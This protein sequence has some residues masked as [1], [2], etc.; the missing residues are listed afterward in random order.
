[1]SSV[2]VPASINMKS[3]SLIIVAAYFAM[4]LFSSTLSCALAETGASLVIYS[5][6]IALAPPWNLLILPISS[7]AIK[8]LLI[9]DSDAPVISVNSATVID[10][11]SFSASKIAV[12]LS[13]VIIIIASCLLS[14]SPV[15]VFSCLCIFFFRGFSECIYLHPVL[16]T[17]L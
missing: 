12:Y 3:S 11:L 17:F 10:F 13:S 1:M 8:S 16:L 2:L 14:M 6:S 4:A 15:Y 9:V 5:C 7:R